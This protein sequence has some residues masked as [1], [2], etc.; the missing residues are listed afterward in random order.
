MFFIYE[1][2][3][4]I[5]VLEKGGYEYFMLKEI[6]EQFKMVVD[7]MCGCFSVDEGWICLGGLEEFF[8][9]VMQVEC[10]IIVVCGIFWY[11]GLVVEYLFE[12]LVCI[13]VEVEYVLELCYCN[14]IIFEKDLVIVIFQLGEMVD[15]LVVLE[16]VK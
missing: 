8:N 6:Y 14:L 1:L 15:I 11:V 7:C 10:F 4:K 12:D 5:E 16:L 9:W 2:D 13:L 3:M